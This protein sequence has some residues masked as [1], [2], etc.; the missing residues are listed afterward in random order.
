MPVR[1]RLRMWFVLAS[2]LGSAAAWPGPAD[3]Y[4][5]AQLLLSSR[6]LTSP[7]PNAA[8][9]PAG[10][11]GRADPI[12]G[13]LKIERTSMRT[14]PSLDGAL[15]DGRDPHLFPAVALEFFSMGDV[16]VP[17][18]RGEMVAESAS[19]KPASYWQVI[20]QFG[21]VWK[22]AGDGGWSRAA[23]PLM[24][25]NDTE[26][27]AHQGLATFLYRGTRISGLRFQ[28]VQQTTPYLIAR[29]F[30][31]WGHASAR[32][33]ASVDA[34]AAA[35]RETAQHELADRLPSRPWRDLVA[36]APPGALDGFGA[37]LAPE[38]VVINAIVRNGTLY[39]GDSATPYGPYPYP[40]EMRFGPRSLLKS[41]GAPLALLRLAT[42]YG[43]AVLDLK[44]GDYVQV[45]DP[46]YRRVRFI[47]A[48]D[49]A[50]GMGG[51]GSPKTNPNDVNDGYV[52]PHYDDW[53]LAASKAGKMREIDAHNLPYPWEPG[54]V[55]RYRDHDFYL[56][57]AALDGYLKSVRGNDA[58][59]WDMLCT[60][61]FAPIG[62]HHAP[63]VRTREPAGAEGLAWFSAGY[64][65]TLDD[66]AKIATLYQNRGQFAG[67]QILDPK[68]TAG[69]FSTD[70]AIRQGADIGQG[71]LPPDDDVQELLYKMGFH[72]YP[73]VSVRTGQKIYVPTMRGS[74]GNMLTL[75]PNGIIS[76]R[77][78]K[79]WPMPK[80]EQHTEDS[81]LLMMK[82][83]E[84]LAAY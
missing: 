43:P 20:P 80:A 55:M 32:F 16:L 17:V 21:R 15:I 33:E 65:P 25:V 84:R 30:V 42:L 38:W 28:F 72:Y 44:I 24:L 39:Y 76:M 26:N 68:L 6:P 63:I 10:D 14:L 37:P 69:I 50:T 27:H 54:T 57:G 66:L 71:R 7:V 53:Y 31:A 46:K 23:F 82:A 62:I 67:R 47:D 75:Y 19:A 52:D 45:A 11:A 34:G 51:A 18:Q 2:L 22:E 5:P 49:M 77:L 3:R 8:F 58:D 41:I 36:G 13:V 79:A 74:S 56:L 59:I 4:L 1:V 40:L 35:M 61:V 9:I 48:A 64:Y 78:A 83:V 29:H 70:D 73:I 60:E 81:P 12:A